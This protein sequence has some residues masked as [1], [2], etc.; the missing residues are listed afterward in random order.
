VV[1]GTTASDCLQIKS[2]VPQGSVLGPLLFIIMMNDLDCNVPTDLILYADD[3]T[4]VTR[5]SDC[6]HALALS[7]LSKMY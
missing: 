3:T 5:R 4:S 7:K 2:G 1:T 6:I